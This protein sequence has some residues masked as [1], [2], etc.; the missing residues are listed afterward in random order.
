MKNIY[1]FILTLFFFGCQSSLIFSKKNLSIPCPSILFSSEH[2]NYIDSLSDNLS[3]ENIDYSAE[4]NNAIFT[5][6]CILK[7][8]IFLS[9]LSIL[10]ILRSHTDNIDYVEMPF[11]VAILNQD[12]ELKEI[13]YFMAFGNFK[14]DLN[15]NQ[16]IETEVTKN[17]ILNNKNINKDSIIVVGYMLDKKRINLLN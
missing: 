13:L 5:K 15:S 2:S 8:N 11:Y 14:K 16:L 1:L 6:K 7:D 4:I 10:F 9:E 12:K 3:I 17:I